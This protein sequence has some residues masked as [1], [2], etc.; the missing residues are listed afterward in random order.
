MAKFRRV[1]RRILNK[2]AGVKKTP[3]AAGR[4]GL[5]CT[6]AEELRHF[7]REHVRDTV[8]CN[9]FPTQIG[10]CVSTPVSN[11]KAN[12]DRLTKMGVGL[13]VT[14]SLILLVLYHLER[15]TVTFNRYL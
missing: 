7:G 2:N 14:V 15:L 3:I 5:D 13:G 9:D 12:K 10:P 8:G 6:L 1:S 4:L 11:G